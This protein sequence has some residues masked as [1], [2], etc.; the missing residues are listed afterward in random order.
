MQLFNGLEYMYI[1]LANAAGKDDL[2]WNKRISWG[3]KL[4]ENG[5]TEG[6]TIPEPYLFVKTRNHIE[7]ALNKIPTG[8]TMGLDCTASGL[9]I[10]AALTGCKKTAERVNLVDT[11]R[12]E[13]AYRFT[14]N[15]MNKKY[16]TS[17]TRKEVKT[18]M[19]T[20]FYNSTAKPKELFGEDTPE[21]KAYYD[22]LNEYFPGAME[23][24]QAT[25]GCW[26]SDA[27]SHSWT[28]PDGQRA[29]C[30]VM[31]Y[32]DKKV[33][34]QELGK[35]TFTY[36]T[37]VNKPDD[38]GLSL[39]ANIVQSVDA[40]I[41]RR[42]ILGAKELGFDL[43]CIFDS[44]WA[45]PNHIND[46]RMLFR[47]ILIEIADSNLLEDILNEITGGNGIY[48]KRSKDLSTYIFNSEYLI[49]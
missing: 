6:E 17:V 39:P 20:T 37:L 7:K 18:P 15:T 29:E 43:Y 32:E 25:Q 3:K 9:Q 30:K 19:M 49:C 22:T 13:D 31:S 24:L 2:T 38:F 36:R 8:Y 26:N 21:L 28:L 5:A 12:R 11:G 27:Y 45:S 1:A 16:G 23:Y 48:V 33:E 46:V 42:M 10:I 47:N 40:Y 44:F 34:V 4:F 41:V 14:A 35:S